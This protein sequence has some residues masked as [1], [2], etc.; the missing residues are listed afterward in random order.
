[1]EIALADDREV[2]VRGPTVM[3]GYFKDPQATAAAFNGDGWFYTGDLGALEPDG[4]LRIVGRKKDLFY[5]TDGSNICPSFIELRLENEPCIRQ[6]ILL[7][8][9]LP[10]IAALVVPDRERI[11]AMVGCAAAG[12]SESQISAAV[13]TN[14][15]RVNR[16]LEA[17]EQIKRYAICP[18]DFPPQARSVNMFQ[19]IKVDRAWVAEHYKNRIAALYA[20]ESEG[21]QH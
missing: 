2:L 18:D 11:A 21:G 6:A 9:H 13:R 17:A 4:S 20:P 10:F 12:L 15:E 7:G 1:V 19:K 16:G 3:P 8:D 14:I 5:C